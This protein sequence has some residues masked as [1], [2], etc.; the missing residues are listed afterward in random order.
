MDA[1]TATAAF[2]VFWPLILLCVCITMIMSAWLRVQPKYV[3]CQPG[4]GIGGP[5][6]LSPVQKEQLAIA[7]RQECLCENPRMQ[8]RG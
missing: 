1:V 3:F 8:G 7:H 2:A 5:W 4:G 6:L